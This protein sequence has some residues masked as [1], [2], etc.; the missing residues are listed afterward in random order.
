MFDIDFMHCI[1]MIYMTAVRPTSI[2]ISGV[3]HHAVQG[4]KVLLQCQVMGARPEVDITWFNRTEE[5]DPNTSE[6]S[7]YTIT[8]KHVRNSLYIRKVIQDLF[9]SKTEF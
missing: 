1:L 3:K 5:L 4:T 7:I 6:S 8:T 2:S 9:I